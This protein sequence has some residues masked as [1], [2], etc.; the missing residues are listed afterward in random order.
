MVLGY[1]ILYKNLALGW[2]NNLRLV[3]EPTAE[4]KTESMRKILENRTRNRQEFESVLE[5]DPKLLENWNQL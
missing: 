2:L 1:F 4:P 5:Q 3:L